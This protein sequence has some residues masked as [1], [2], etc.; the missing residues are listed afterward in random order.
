MTNSIVNEISFPEPKILPA[1]EIK[2][3]G[4]PE[5]PSPINPMPMKFIVCD[6]GKIAIDNP[7]R[8]TTDNINNKVPALIL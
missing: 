2:S 5:K 8:L 7:E 4:I 3:G 1:D 6:S